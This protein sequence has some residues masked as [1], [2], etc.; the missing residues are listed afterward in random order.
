VRAVG[1]AV[2]AMVVGACTTTTPTGPGTFTEVY[3]MM[4]PTG[5]NGRCNFCHGLPANNTSNG[6]LHMGSDKDAAYAALVGKSSKGSMCVGKLLIDVADPS[7]SLFLLKLSENP[8]CGSR[9]PLG[10]NLLNDAQREVVRSWIANGAL[11]D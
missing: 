1:F 2:A 11:N 6:L 5:T 10:G 9:M 3:D 8:V 4:F 7:Q